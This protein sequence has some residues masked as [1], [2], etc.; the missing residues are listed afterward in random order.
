MWPNSKQFRMRVA[1]LIVA[2]RALGGPW[3]R[4]CSE[5][6]MILC[7]VKYIQTLRFVCS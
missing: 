7:I 6:V 4:A 5:S 1:G 2:I 3:A